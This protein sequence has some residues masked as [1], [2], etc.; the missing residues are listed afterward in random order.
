MAS[1]L[2][3]LS[4]KNKFARA[5][6]FF[7]AF[8]C[9]YFA[10]LQRIEE[11]SYVLAKTFV[12]RVP[13]AAMKFSCFF[14]QRISS[15]LFLIARSSPFSVIYV[16]VNIKNNVEKRLDFAVVFFSPKARVA[17]RFPSK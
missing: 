13:A 12:S 1:R 5:V 16:S 7:C 14:F 4:I 11:L 8:L 17:M 15:P 2:R 10:R 6:H 3:D 9:R